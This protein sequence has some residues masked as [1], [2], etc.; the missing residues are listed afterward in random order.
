MGR[1]QEPH[2]GESSYGVL[3]QSAQQPAEETAVQIWK[4]TLMCSR[5]PS[6][7]RCP[8][9]AT[10]KNEASFLLDTSPLSYLLACPQPGL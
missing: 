7:D 4:L 3:V 5:A 10:Q 8:L 1:A 2:T 6:P 9:L